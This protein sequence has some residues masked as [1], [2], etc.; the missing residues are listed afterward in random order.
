MQYLLGGSI[1]ICILDLT[2]Q[3]FDMLAIIILKTKNLS[4]KRL[5]KKPKIIQPMNKDSNQVHLSQSTQS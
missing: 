3:Q 5:T 1:V 4:L 2:Q